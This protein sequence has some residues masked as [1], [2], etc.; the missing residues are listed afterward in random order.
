MN[1][2]MIRLP[3]VIKLTGKSRSS[4]YEDVVKGKFPDSYKIGSRSVAWKLSE[5]QSWIEERR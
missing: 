2:R 3:E 5:I 4:I 1:D